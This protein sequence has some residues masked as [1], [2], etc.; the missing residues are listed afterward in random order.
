MLGPLYFPLDSA[1]AQLIAAYASFGLAFIAR[2]LGAMAFGHF[3]DRL[4]R[5]STLVASLLLMGGSTLA[6]AFVPSYQQIGWPAPALL[7]LLRIGQGLGLGGEWGGAALLA[8]EN[9]PPGWR[10]RFGMFPQLGA[11]VG[12]IMSNGLFLILSLALN[13][14]Q[15]HAWG[16]RLPFLASAALVA[17]GLWV[18]LRLSETPAFLAALNSAPP[19]RIPLSELMRDHWGAA[20]NG[21]IVAIVCFAL[22][23]LSTAFALGYG[24]SRLGYSRET[25]L[26]IQL[27]AVLFLGPGIVLAAW[28]ADL[29]GA[30]RVL[31]WGCAATAVVGLLL[32]T[33]LASR[34]LI[35]IAGYLSLAMFVMGFVYGPLGAYLTALFPAR[36]RYTGTSL[37]FNVAG[38]LGGGLTP[39]MAEALAARGALSFVGYYLAAAAAASLAGLATA[40]RADHLGAAM[41]TRL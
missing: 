19:P 21:A 16:W 39:I 36:I 22:F 2:P 13:N 4:G 6:I 10:A 41:L 11:P 25:F 28:L 32:D 33:M 35:L 14:E 38:V 40:K 30:R 9:A 29:R 7:C 34:S 37:S 12:F 26:S 1:A 18:R 27:A 20:A 17:V 8:V 3:G 31:I 24:T 5:K 15:F 23:Y